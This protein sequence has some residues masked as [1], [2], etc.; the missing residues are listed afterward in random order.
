MTRQ[1]K[2]ELLRAM[3]RRLIVLGVWDSDPE[4][5]TDSDESL[6]SIM[7]AMLAAIERKA[8]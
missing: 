4:A 7:A 2:A 5:L 6:L 3:A 1:A 8:A